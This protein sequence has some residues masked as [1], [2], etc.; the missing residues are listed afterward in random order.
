MQPAQPDTPPLL[1]DP[2]ALAA[3]LAR[4]DR[5]GPRYTSYPTAVEF[6]AG[7]GPDEYGR[8]LVAA[9]A[10]GDAPLSAYLHLPFCEHR[11]LFCGCH[12]I[13]SPHHEKTGGY[14]DLL[15]REIELVAERLPRRRQVSQLH[16]GGGTPTYHAPEE[17]DR[18][19]ARFRG[20]FELLPGAELAVEIDPRVTSRAHLDALAAH[21]FNRVSFGVQDLSRYVQEAIERIQ[22][23]EETQALIEH[24]RDLGFG[25]VNVDLIYG[26]PLQDELGFGRT[27]DAVIELGVDR[28]AVYSFAL[29]PWIRGHQKSIDERDLPDRDAKFRLF[30]LARERFLAAGYEPI[31]MDHFARPDD[32]LALAKREGRLRRNFQGYS[33]VPGADVVGFGIS[34]IGDVRGAYVQNEKKLSTYEEAVRAGRLPIERG[35]ARSADDELRRDVIQE[36]MCNLRVD[37]RAL[38][39]RH[40][41]SF[42]QTFAEDL[43]RLAP[44]AAEGMVEVGADALQVTPLGALFLRNLAM[45]FDR[46]WR[47][48]HEG[49]ERP[50]F[51]RTV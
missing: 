49:G 36:L 43:R 39:A 1:G 27:V 45:C 8:R 46:Y 12:V 37:V 4:H 34:A 18:L 13:I 48:K 15:A 24:A 9:D 44:Y 40:G 35:V 5:P 50:T 25:G 19:I 6:H 21:G 14:L 32:E 41:V 29:V 26:L 20:F 51:S 7:V 23:L 11:C 42:Q 31:G 10:L 2:E 3:L 38:E 22:T 28:A 33:V 17:L 30:A 16:L 47:E